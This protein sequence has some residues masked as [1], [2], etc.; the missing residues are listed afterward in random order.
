M[1]GSSHRSI[2]QL[3]VTGIEGEIIHSWSYLKALLGR[4]PT[5]CSFPFGGSDLEHGVSGIYETCRNLA[6]EAIVTTRKGLVTPCTDSYEI[7]RYD[8][9]HLPPR[10]NEILAG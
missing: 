10:S 1:H 5:W 2:S 8:C 6:V 4:A 3:G 9:I 7:P